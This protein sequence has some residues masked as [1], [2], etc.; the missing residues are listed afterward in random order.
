MVLRNSQNHKNSKFSLFIRKI[1]PY[2]ELPGEF[3][4]HNFTHPDQSALYKKTGIQKGFGITVF[5]KIDLERFA[6]GIGI[7]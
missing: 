5:R 6:D 7:L 1:N 4:S 2:F 3:S